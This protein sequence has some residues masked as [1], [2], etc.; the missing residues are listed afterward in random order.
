[1][2]ISIGVLTWNEEESIEATLG[3]LFRQSIFRLVSDRGGKTEVLVVANGCTD[4]TQE[5]AQAVFDNS[6]STKIKIPEDVRCQVVEL[7]ERGKVNAWNVFVH[8]LS[9]NEADYL[10]LMDADILVNERDAMW[11]M[12]IALETD[13]FAQVSTDQP[14]K[15]VKHGAASPLTRLISLGTSKMTQAGSAQLTGQLYCIRASM[16]RKIRL[17][18]GLLVEDGFIKTLVCTDLLTAESNSNRIARTQ[19]ASHVFQA[20]TAIGDVLNNQKRQKVAQTIT[21]FLCE[22]FLPRLSRDDRYRFAETV[23]NRETLDPEWCIRPFKEYVR[24][25]TR[26]WNLYPD[27]LTFRFRRLKLLGG[28]SRIGYFP[29]AIAGFCVDLITCYQAHRSLRLQQVDFWPDT[30]TKYVAK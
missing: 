9:N 2:F 5:L 13:S 14:V 26:F 10:F 1:M 17:P 28:L 6:Q 15:D 25:T 4:R 11:S 24:S 23:M 27:A 18:R 3:S 19:D 21:Y 8:E 20:Y 30:R 16:A 22:Q 7:K 29:V 12:L